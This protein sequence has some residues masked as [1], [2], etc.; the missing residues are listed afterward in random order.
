MYAIRSYYEEDH[1]GDMDFKV[2]GT[3]K[4]ITAFQMDIKI[5]GISKEIMTVALNQAHQGRLYIL[6][7]MNSVI[8]E[9]SDTI[10]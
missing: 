4:G 8:S 10:P 5:S 7:K 1:M 9:P 6:D 2:A 3:A